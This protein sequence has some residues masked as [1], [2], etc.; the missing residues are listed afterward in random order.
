[1]V[2]HDMARR[3]LLKAGAGAFGAAM[4][5]S[6]LLATAS[7]VQKPNILFIM[8]DDLG[9]A[10]LSCYGHGFYQTPHLDRIASQGMR[11]EQA[12]ANSAVCSATRVAL[13]TGRYQYR[14]R[15]GLEEPFGREGDLGLEPG[16]P[17][18]PSILKEAGYR[19]SLIGKWHLGYPPK[20]HPLKSGYD[21]FFGIYGGAADYFE[22]STE[23][24]SSLSGRLIDQDKEVDRP[25]YLTDQFGSAAIEEITGAAARKQPFFMSL[26][27]T[28]PHWPWEG[29]EDEEV[30]RKL[31]TIDHLDGGSVE[32]YA[33]MLRSM[34]ENIGRVMA[35]LDRLGLAE[36]TIVVFTSDNGGERFSATWPLTG[37]KTELLEGGIRVPLLVRWPG[38]I[39][40]G[41]LST[42]TAM[43]MDFLPTLCAAANVANKHPTD[44]ENLL[45]HLLGRA[46]A[47]PRQLFWRYK[48]MDQ[49]AVRDGDWKYLKING[50]EFLFNL[51]NDQRERANLSQ[52]EKAR[53]SSMKLL[54][55]Q[56][57]AQMLPYPLSSSSANVK[58]KWGFADR[59]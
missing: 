58:E 22:H 13:I 3:S 2:D 23:S 35:T 36:N 47:T 56:W 20:F 41:S 43:S 1:M 30:A 9:Y 50:K 57:N 33:K 38:R 34:D 39:A 48:A 31:K 26:H 11:F 28:A 5:P 18:L 45:P 27:F 44:G 14:L 12:Y 15:A 21:R 6:R 10:D 19:T 29:P 54:F 37:M 32:I 52:A 16:Q 8:A 42:Q 46:E 59:Y 51:A 25:G 24:A 4:I 7:G 53:F 55:D 17:T 49:V 40:A